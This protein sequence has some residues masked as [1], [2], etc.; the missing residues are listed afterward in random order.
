MNP[1]GTEHGSA[2]AAVLLVATVVGALI[3]VIISISVVEHRMVVDDV[4]RWE[5][6]YAAEAGLHTALVASR[7]APPGQ[8]VT[9]SDP[10]GSWEAGAMPYGAYVMVESV[11]RA[12]RKHVALRGW[13]GTP[14]TLDAAIVSGHDAV[15]LAIAGTAVVRGDIYTGPAGVVMEGRPEEGSI[16][17]SHPGPVHQGTVHVAPSS[18]LP[19]IPSSSIPEAWAMAENLIQ[20]GVQLARV[21]EA[22]TLDAGD[23]VT[24]R[25]VFAEG[26]LFLDAQGKPLPDGTIILARGRIQL[27]RYRGGRRVL[28]IGD[29]GIDIGAGHATIHAVSRGHIRVRPGAVLDAPSTVTVADSS[30]RL[31]IEGTVYGSVV[32][33]GLPPASSGSTSTSAP[34]LTFSRSA[35]LEGVAVSNRPCLPRGQFWGT[36]MCSAFLSD[37]DGRLRSA[38]LDRV[39]VDQER[40]HDGFTGPALIGP[41]HRLVLFDQEV[42]SLD[43]VIIL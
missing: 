30:G 4:R 15:P 35:I 29:G 12:G 19:I 14:L 16:A 43:D 13:A 38:R 27:R 21:E 18:R 36:L 23:L 34:A 41:T 9:T 3:G 24:A 40:R 8:A 28:L 26:D 33:G 42:T 20:S 2:L 17:T 11:G 25:V 6:W 1:G 7:S 22:T 37:A 39:T 31:T 32:V 5:A 10:G